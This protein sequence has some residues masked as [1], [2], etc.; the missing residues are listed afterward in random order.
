MLG[1][2]KAKFLRA[3]NDGGNNGNTDAMYELCDIGLV[4][5]R[6]P[7]PV[8]ESL[9]AEKQDIEST[10][11]AFPDIVFTIQELVTE[12]S[13]AVMRWTWRAKH[14]GQEPDLHTPPTDSEVSMQGCSVFRLANGKII[15]EWEFADYL[16]FFTQ[17][18]A[19]P[20]FD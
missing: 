7:F 9:E 4:H 8:I 20:P 11:K 17:L 2:L 18:G 12:G 1:E 5:H 16:G 15:L 19:I 10:F 14:T 6:P 3:F 13:T